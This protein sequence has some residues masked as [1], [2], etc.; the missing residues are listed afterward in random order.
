[1]A[2]N[3]EGSVLPIL[4]KAS[5]SAAAIAANCFAPKSSF[6]SALKYKSY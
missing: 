2:A 4:A 5:F 3:G 1:M 6:G